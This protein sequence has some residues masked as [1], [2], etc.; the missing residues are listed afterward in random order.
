M[1][2]RQRNAL[3]SQSSTQL[4]PATA[5][6]QRRNKSMAGHGTSV[7]ARSLAEQVCVCVWLLLAVR[8]HP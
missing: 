1:L 4:R 7:S 5:R 6:R 2:G 8:L 3:S